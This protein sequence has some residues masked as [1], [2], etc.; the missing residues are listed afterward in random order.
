VAGRRA[1]A[2]AGCLELPLA[3]PQS[4]AELVGEE[5]WPAGGLA[6]GSWKVGGIGWGE[7]F[8]SDK[9]RTFSPFLGSDLARKPFGGGG[10]G[11][12]V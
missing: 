12:G 1:R 9:L 6:E 5:G 11:G 2:P 7:S 3:R 10:G 4:I 8:P